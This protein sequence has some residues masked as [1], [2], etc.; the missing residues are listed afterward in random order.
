M[1]LVVGLGNPGRKY[2]GNRHNVGFRVIDELARRHGITG[3]RDK[4]GSDVATGMFELDKVV[5]QKPM[6]YMNRSGFAVQ[7][8]ADFYG[9]EAER[10]V[11]IHDDIDLDVG[12][13]KL[14]RSGG[15]GG[16][17]GL[18]SLIEQLGSR[19]F[20]RIRCGVGKPGPHQS[21]GNG[22]TAAA[23]GERDRRVSGYVLSDFPSAQAGTVEQLIDRA[24]DAVESVVARG[25][26]ASMN[27]FNI[28][29]TPAESD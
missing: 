27:E 18:R 21:A 8:A 3:F 9:L 19:D 12:R 22:N 10:I 14:K 1:W 16:H 11:V 25:I 20:A 5:L 26:T 6:E 4:F 23:A 15:H 17:N 13:L 7:R 28:R 24:A 2:A 29:E